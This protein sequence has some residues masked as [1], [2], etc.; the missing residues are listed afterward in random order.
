MKR[1]AVTEN[2]GAI[3]ALFKIGS[4][5]LYNKRPKLLTWHGMGYSGHLYYKTCVILVQFAHTNAKSTHFIES[6]TKF[7][8]NECYTVYVSNYYTV[9][10]RTAAM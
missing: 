6:Q 7:L 10:K 4:D 2:A 5:L 9:Y 1:P 3:R 8:K